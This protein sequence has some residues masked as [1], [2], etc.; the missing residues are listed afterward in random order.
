MVIIPTQGFED[1]KR[2]LKIEV[3]R[4]EKAK[5]ERDCIMSAIGEIQRGWLQPHPVR[6]ELIM[7]VPST[8]T[9]IPSINQ[10]LLTVGGYKEIKHI[11]ALKEFMV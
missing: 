10:E 6:K 2:S 4:G 1:G 9:G 3:G 5:A 8:S 7:I 11:L